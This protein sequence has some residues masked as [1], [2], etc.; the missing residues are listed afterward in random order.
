MIDYENFYNKTQL[1][2]RWSKGLLDKFAGNPDQEAEN[3]YNTED[4]PHATIKLYSKERIHNIELTEVF[5]DAQ[6]RSNNFRQMMTLKK[7][8]YKLQY[9][10]LSRWGKIAR[11]H[12]N[13]NNPTNS[14]L[15]YP[16]EEVADYERKFIKFFAG[17]PDVVS[18][19]MALQKIEWFEKQRIH[20]I[21]ASPAFI[22]CK[23]EAELAK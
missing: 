3:P 15:R 19:G 5:Q 1:M 21:E 9:D 17:E 13:F 8:Y 7:R 14:W 11:N 23:T 16:Y 22:K 4:Q 10:L 20:N 12:Y 6:E 2:N 18:E